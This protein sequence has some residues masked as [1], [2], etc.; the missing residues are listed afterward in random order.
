VSNFL[1]DVVED[2]RQKI[3][4]GANEIYYKKDLVEGI[5]LIITLVGIIKIIALVGVIVAS[6]ISSMVSFATNNPKA[7]AHLAKVVSKY[8][9][10]IIEIITNFG[11]KINKSYNSL[12]ENK[13]KAVRTVVL[14]VA[15][16]GISW[17]DLH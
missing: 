1:E 9:N 2:Y 6:A 3:K 12:S 7:A 5:K 4:K 8:S 17:N 15:K 14:L 10:D 16:N 11:T 13:K